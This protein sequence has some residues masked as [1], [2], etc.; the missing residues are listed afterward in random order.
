ME[1]Y[2]ATLKENYTVLEPI[3][4]GYWN[5][6][7]IYSEKS[8]FRNNISALRNQKFVEESILATKFVFG[9]IVRLKTRFIYKTKESTI[10][11]K[12][13]GQNCEKR[14]CPLHHKQFKTLF[15]E[16]MVRLKIISLYLRLKI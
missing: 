9:D 14:R 10:L 6:F 12:N 3:E 16:H 1:R 8:C 13:Y 2:I 15:R 5:S 7:L 11:T 4:S